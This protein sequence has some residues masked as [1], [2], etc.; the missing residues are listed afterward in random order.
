MPATDASADT[1]SDANCG[2]EA[3]DFDYRP[4]NAL[5]IFDRSCSMRRRLDDV[6]LFGTGPDDV[7]TVPDQQTTMA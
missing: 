6:S 3:V 1:G 7:N 4:P 2:G 5:V